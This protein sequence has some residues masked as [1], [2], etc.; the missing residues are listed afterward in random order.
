MI[1]DSPATFCENM[2]LIEHFSTHVQGSLV[3]CGTWKGGMACAMMALAGPARDYH[4]FDSFEGLPDAQDI[5]GDG[6]LSYQRNTG[7]PAYRDNCRADHDEFLKLMN[8]QEIPAERIN[9]YKGWF[10]NTLP[11]Y[12]GG[13]ISVL[14][15]DG[16]WYESTM[17]CLRELYPKVAFGG[18]VIID[19]YEAWDGCTKAVH[20]YLGDIS[21][22]SRIDRTPV[23]HVA[24][25][26]KLDEC[27][28]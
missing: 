7:S 22:R 27:T 13:P 5:D 25:I 24:F 10:E 2:M 28:G 1:A 14:R 20:D 15:L 9:V 23:S 19:D 3:E 17:T 6:A 21:S 8:E 16:D 18:V 11:T 12:A 4:F 26:Q